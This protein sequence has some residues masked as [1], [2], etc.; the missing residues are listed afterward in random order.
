MIDVSDKMLVVLDLVNEDEE[1]QVIGFVEEINKHNITLIVAESG[2]VVCFD[3]ADDDLITGQV[4]GVMVETDEDDVREQTLNLL[5][6]IKRTELRRVA[7]DVANVLKEMAD[8]TQTSKQEL[9]DEFN[10]L[11]IPMV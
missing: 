3:F 9:L 10:E 6:Q 7:L 8:H 1:V 11:L 4:L 5:N 2:D